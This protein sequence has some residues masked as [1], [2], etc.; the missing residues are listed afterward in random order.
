MPTRRIGRNE[1][2]PC[3]DVRVNGKRIAIA[4]VRG[5]GNVNAHIQWSRTKHYGEGP[6][7]TGAL[8]LSVTGGDFNDLDWDRFVRWVDRRL[9][10]GDQV[11]I[12]VIEGVKPRPGRSLSRSKRIPLDEWPSRRNPTSVSVP[13]A[14]VCAL[15]SRVWLGVGK[16]VLGTA[17]LPPRQAT[18]IGKGLIEAA[19]VVR[20]REAERSAVRRRA[21]RT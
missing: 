2:S 20:A 11:E 8:R 21:R 18:K 5:E 1:P 16:R 17:S 19:E 12:R 4:G 6:W 13:G 14:E 3:L 9:R 10:V 7:A 15:S